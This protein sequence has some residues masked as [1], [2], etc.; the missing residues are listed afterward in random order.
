MPSI[1]IWK[2]NEPNTSKKTIRFYSGSNWVLEE[3][4]YSSKSYIYLEQIVISESDNSV[5]TFNSKDMPQDYIG[6]ELLEVTNIPY[7][8]VKSDNYGTLEKIGNWMRFISKNEIDFEETSLKNE[9]SIIKIWMNKQ[10][11]DT[12]NKQPYKEI[13]QNS[14]ISF[15]QDKIQID[16]QQFLVKYNVSQINLDNIPN[17]INSNP[18]YNCNPRYNNNNNNT[19]YKKIK[20]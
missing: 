13:K 16:F 20:G 5:I 8:I 19:K 3:S 1:F 17:I 9:F 12:Y 18:R 11:K 6:T 10:N 14:E 4:D 15:D 7:E 2:S